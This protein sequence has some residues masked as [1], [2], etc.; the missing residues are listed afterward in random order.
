MN[1]TI[2]INV[3]DESSNRVS[4]E[5]SN[6]QGLFQATLRPSLKVPQ[7]SERALAPLQG[8][9]IAMLCFALTRMH[10]NSGTAQVMTQ[11]DSDNLMLNASLYGFTG[12]Q[13]GKAMN[14]IDVFLA[15][16]KANPDILPT[17]QGAQ[18]VYQR[19][20]LYCQD[21]TVGA[22]DDQCELKYS[23]LAD[24]AQIPWDALHP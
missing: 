8:Q 2:N 22:W 13:S 7:D 19:F 10:T 5:L 16:A 3:P 17:L 11:P 12:H 20:K 23:Q 6:R 21:K 15:F 14:G 24:M 18:A 1:L 4:D 9:L